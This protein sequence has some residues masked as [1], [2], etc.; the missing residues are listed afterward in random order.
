MIGRKLP[1]ADNAWIE[2][3]A[4]AE[5]E[6]LPTHA[7]EK[8]VALWQEL[9]AQ[10]TSTQGRIL[11]RMLKLIA[12]RGDPPPPKFVEHVARLLAEP[13]PRSQIRDQQGFRKA[14][15]H[16]ALNPGASW[17]ELATAAG[18]APSTVR[19]WVQHRKFQ[20]LVR[21]ARIREGRWDLV[22]HTVDR[23]PES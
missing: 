10:P 22:I 14:A 5:L 23:P 4:I 19:Q 7:W 8:M 2:E 12:E 1:T 16:L 21:D 6:R 3:T 9:P 11:T 20:L 13:R 15:E 17:N 18:V